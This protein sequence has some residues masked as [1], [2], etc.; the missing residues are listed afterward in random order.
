MKYYLYHIPGK[1]VGVTKSL[2]RRVEQQQGYAPHEYE[3]L[4]E[5][6]DIDYISTRERDLQKMFGYRVDETLYKNLNQN[7]SMRI[8][9]TEQTTTFPCPVSK[10]KGQLMDNLGLVIQ[11]AFNRHELT[12]GLASW[13]E[14]NA[15]TSQFNDG[16]CYVYNKAMSTWA[17][18]D[19]VNI[20]KQISHSSVFQRIRDWAEERGIYDRGDSNTQYVKLME[21]AGELA[22]GLLKK[23]KPEIIDAIGDMVVVLTNLAHMEGMDIEN[24]V[25][26]AYT[27][28]KNRQGRMV[29]GT[30]VKDDSDKAF[31]FADKNLDLTSNTL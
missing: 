23:D 17:K 3:I 25:Q 19:M 2:A 12:S 26:S 16:R 7:K 9:I 1:K 21:E 4:E 18:K 10:L 29:N 24:C 6:D 11:T 14:R 5:S 31:A 8:N 20:D 28:I 22:Q 27:E 13:I 15:V 30:F